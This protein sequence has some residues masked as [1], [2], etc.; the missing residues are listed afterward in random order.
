MFKEKSEGGEMFG[1]RK[2]WGGPQAGKSELA[3]FGFLWIWLGCCCASSNA[4]TQEKKRC[5]FKLIRR[6]HVGF[7]KSIKAK[8]K[9][10]NHWENRH[11]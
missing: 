10:L 6:D 9:G 1:Y 2:I 4:H 7:I 11:S 8:A 3:F 5:K